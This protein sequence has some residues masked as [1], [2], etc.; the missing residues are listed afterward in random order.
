MGCLIFSI[1]VSLFLCI[2]VNAIAEQEY[3]LL[4]CLAGKVYNLVLQLVVAR[5]DEV[6]LFAIQGMGYGEPG[7][8]V[9]AVLG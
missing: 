7:S 5:S 1:F 4:L 9:F 8:S 3:K 6:A 2:V